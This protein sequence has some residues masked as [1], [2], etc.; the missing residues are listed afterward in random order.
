MNLL[1]QEVIMSL[2]PPAD[3]IVSAILHDHTLWSGPV[4]TLPVESM[5]VSTFLSQ[6]GDQPYGQFEYLG[7]LTAVPIGFD[8]VL[9]VFGRSLQ[10]L[11]R[12]RRGSRSSGSG[13]QYI[14]TGANRK[15]STLLQYV[16]PYNSSSCHYHRRTREDFF[17]LHGHCR[18]GLVK[19]GDGETGIEY[20]DLVGS[21]LAV[22]KR[23]IHQMKTYAE[24]AVN[25]LVM[26][27][28]KNPRDTS[29]HHY[30]ESPFKF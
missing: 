9:Y 11:S 13:C 21:S 27:G 2:F 20:A 17:N 24:P 25:F 29:D 19:V 6:N 18:L 7:H 26:W 22:P 23:C 4:D 28:L 8:Y 10:I 30:V 3:N 14:G 12:R 15:Y 5:L 1:L 16:P